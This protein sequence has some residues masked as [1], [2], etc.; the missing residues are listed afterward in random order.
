MAIVCNKGP[1]AHSLSFFFTYIN[2]K[3][4]GKIKLAFN[5]AIWARLQNDQFLSYMSCRFIINM[6]HQKTGPGSSSDGAT[7]TGGT[8][9]MDVIDGFTNV[10]II[11][12]Y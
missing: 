4:F 3:R 1:N 7:G 6:A 8:G 12:A 5:C 10:F 2:L 9:M 11:E